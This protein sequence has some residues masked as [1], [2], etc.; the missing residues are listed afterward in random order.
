M[1]EDENRRIPEV[2]TFSE[3]IWLALAI[4]S[5]VFTL[6]GLLFAFWW[7]FLDPA[8]GDHMTERSRAV[9]PFLAAGAAAVTFFS[10]LWR[11]TINSR[12]ADEDRRQ[13]DSREEAELALL[14]EKAS[15]FVASER[16]EKVSLGLTMFETVV[17]ADNRKYAAPALELVYDQLVPAH[18]ERDEFG[19]RIIGQIERIFINAKTKKNLKP[20]RRWLD[21]SAVH[22]EGGSK[23]NLTFDFRAI[24][25]VTSVI[26]AKIYADPEELAKLKEE[27]GRCSFSKCNFSFSFSFEA[28]VP[29]RLDNW[30]FFE[31]AFYGLDISYLS[32]HLRSAKCTFEKCDFSGAVFEYSDI[33]HSNTFIECTFAG[34]QPPQIENIVEPD[35]QENL[36]TIKFL[37]EAAN[38]F[39]A[40]EKD[41]IPF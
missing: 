25:P 22:K 4:A 16:P 3:D 28:D 39:P 38:I 20:E 34:D 9:T 35:L 26:G 29:L 21:F 14:L 11:G 7:V 15:D 33:L 37:A 19:L 36:D 27:E 40:I 18:R 8:V 24:Y 5:A 10:V 6:L 13:N 32:W 31:C 30:Y 12:Q 2:P 41:E 23:T 1:G 17:L